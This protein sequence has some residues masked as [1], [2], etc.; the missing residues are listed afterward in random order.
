MGLKA[1][2][3]ERIKRKETEIA[4]FEAKI[5]EARAY[6]QALQ[7]SLKLL[8]KE[9]STESLYAETL[10]PGSNVYKTYEYLKKV[11]RPVHL[12]EILKALGKGTDKNEK[13]N[14]AGTLGAYVRKNQI[15]VRTAPNTFG[16]IDSNKIDEPPDDF[17]VD[18]ED[19]QPLDD[20]PF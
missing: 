12:N 11:G 17:G 5:R 16:L 2:F 19:S 18:K 15:F 7:D 14:L 1:K 20:V 4:E 6:L 13:V 3:E 10:R 8:P 9:S